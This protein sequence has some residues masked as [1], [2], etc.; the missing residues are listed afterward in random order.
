MDVH[1]EL[2]MQYHVWNN[3]NIII[4]IELLS[5]IYLFKLIASFL[6]W[7]WQK[8]IGFLLLTFH[9]LLNLLPTKENVRTALADLK[10]YSFF[11][12]T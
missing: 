1:A 8:S 11:F 6:K 5:D 4:K 12:V 9:L 2:Y 3:N 7:L 10:L